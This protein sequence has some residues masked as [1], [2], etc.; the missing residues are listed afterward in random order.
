MRLH[1]SNLVLFVCAVARKDIP[2]VVYT[3]ALAF[4]GQNHTS[5]V[6][7]D[8]HFAAA[9]MSCMHPEHTTGSVRYNGEVPSPP[10][11][12]DWAHLNC[13]VP[14]LSMTL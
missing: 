11:N 4:Q 6:A 2:L 7:H 12:C 5:L 9:A 1:C 8:D 3:K 13:G 14:A 10:N